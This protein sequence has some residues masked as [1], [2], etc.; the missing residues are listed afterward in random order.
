MKIYRDIIRTIN[1]IIERLEHTE[2]GMTRVILNPNQQLTIF[3]NGMV[4]LLISTDFNN[5]LSTNIKHLTSP[6]MLFERKPLEKK[7]LNIYKESKYIKSRIE[8]LKL[9]ENELSN[10]LND[11]LLELI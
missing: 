5:P 4:Y 3:E 8:T 2:K 11:K 9:N 10:A 6:G 7:P 1:L